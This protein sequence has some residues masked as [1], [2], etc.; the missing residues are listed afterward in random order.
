MVVSNK[1]YIFGAHSRAQTLGVYLTKLNTELEIEAYLVDNEEPN[2]SSV[3]G[4]PVFDVSK[5]DYEFKV[6]YPVYIGTR[7]VYHQSI[8]A[9]LTSLG[10]RKVIPVTPDF[11]M[12]IRNDFLRLYYKEN[13]GELI[14]FEDVTSINNNIVRKSASIYV[15][16][17]AYDKPQDSQYPVNSYEVDLQ[18]GAELTDTRIATITDNKGDN[19]SSRNKQFCELTGLY[20]IWK[21]VG[22]D[23][24]GLEHYRRHFILED[25][26]LD[27]FIANDIDVILPTPLY[28]GPSLA[29]NYRNR[30]IA[31]D[32]DYMLQ[33][34]KEIHPDDY[35]AAK[36][37]FEETAI[38]SPCNMFIM[39]RNILN[40][41]C[42][43]IFPILFAVA[44]HIG[45]HEDA[46]QNRYPGF[47]SERLLS[48]YFEQ[49]RDKYKIVYCDKDFRQ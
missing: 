6:S 49:N 12:K 26:W 48:Y 34:M 13:N 33:V 32:Y 45:E 9:K 31:S 43:W 24:V 41:F 14:K 8:L 17:S 30:H 18:V 16:K 2:P 38:Y 23:I 11:D 28:V 22:E 47:M 21:N 40:E 7:G 42:E 20:W 46:Y 3:E 29:E 19:I 44:E 25:D 37:L 4:V 39:K 35:E 1:I 10:F 15:I 5:D 27:K 36:V